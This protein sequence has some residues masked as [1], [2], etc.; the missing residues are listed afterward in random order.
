MGIALKSM[1]IWPVAEKVPEIFRQIIILFK[2]I[3][4]TLA[5][6]GEG[7]RQGF[8][9]LSPGKDTGNKTHWWDLNRS[10]R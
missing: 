10:H 2:I 3:S 4:T 7:I 5:A 1:Q 9:F 6:S 8:S